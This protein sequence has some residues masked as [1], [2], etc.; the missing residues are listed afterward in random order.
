L[1]AK[2]V[3]KRFLSF[4]FARGSLLLEERHEQDWPESI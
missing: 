4:A 1:L 3:R 2:Q